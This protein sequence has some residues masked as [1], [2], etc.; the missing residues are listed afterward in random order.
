MPPVSPENQGKVE[1][2][3]AD[4]NKL[5]DEK[6]AAAKTDSDAK[7]LDLERQLET[8]KSDARKE[9]EAS[10]YEAVKTALKLGDF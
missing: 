2:L 9:G 10:F 6:V 5:V 7:I 4:I 8:A 1:G 3:V